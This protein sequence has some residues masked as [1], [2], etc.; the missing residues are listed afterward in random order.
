MLKQ[1]EVNVEEVLFPGQFLKIGMDEVEGVRSYWIF[2]PD[3]ISD[4]DSEVEE[5]KKSMK[6]RK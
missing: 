5:S 4:A 6:V 2:V 1:A 3:Y